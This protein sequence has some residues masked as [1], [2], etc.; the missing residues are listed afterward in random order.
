[1]AVG[2][3]VGLG[4]GVWVGVPAHLA[5]R[6]RSL[7]TATAIDSEAGD[8]ADGTSPAHETKPR[9]HVAVIAIT[10]PNSYVWSPLAG[11]ISTLPEAP[12]A[13]DTVTRYLGI[14]AIVGVGERVGVAVLVGVGIAVTVG[15]GVYVGIGTAVAV[16]VAV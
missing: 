16:G 2:D 4:V 15:D 3:G 10:L 9:R 14:G 6:T 1:V 8:A 7:V 5:V 13:T 11:T 12:A